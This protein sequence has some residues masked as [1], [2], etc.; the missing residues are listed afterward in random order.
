M[1]IILEKM[2]AKSIKQ[3]YNYIWLFLKLIR[4]CSHN[5]L[6]ICLPAKIY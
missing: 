4:F 5:I 2:K 6:S 1:D 3:T